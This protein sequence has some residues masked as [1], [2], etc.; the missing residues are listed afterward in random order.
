MNPSQANPP[1]EPRHMEYRD[2]LDALT[3]KFAWS[4]YDLERG[5]QLPT[6]RPGIGARITK[7]GDICYV[8]CYVFVI[9]T[10]QADQ[11]MVHDFASQ[12]TRYATKQRKADIELSPNFVL[13]IPVLVSDDFDGELKA[14][15]CKKTGKVTKESYEVPVLVSSKRREL[16]HQ[17]QISH[18]WSAYTDRIN[19]LVDEMLGF[20]N[21][22]LFKPYTRERLQIDSS[23]R[24]EKKEDYEAITN[25]WHGRKRIP[26]TDDD[27]VGLLMNFALGHA[28]W[29]VSSG[30]GVSPF[31]VTES[32]G[33]RH[34][35]VFVGQPYETA[36]DAARQ[37]LIGADPKTEMCALAFDGYVTMDGVRLDAILVEVVSRGMKG[38]LVAHQRYR[39]K[40]ADQ[41]FEE[42]GRA[43]VQ[44]TAKNMLENPSDTTSP[45]R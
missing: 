16:Y 30:G 45:Y 43:A 20:G 32:E 11:K 33:K 17:K 7:P 38:A 15:I 18:G 8:Y 4:A 19:K 28:L 31:T 41:M 6:Y 12:C 44:R 14:W 25:A 9:G 39:P 29:I 34:V 3:Q 35:N 42:I 24:A 10:N 13:S 21:I 2:Y 23:V 22:D 37:S 26:C 40:K 5:L 27:K 36:V 1:E